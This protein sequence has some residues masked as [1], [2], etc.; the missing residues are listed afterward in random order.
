M[1]LIVRRGMGARE[2]VVV[3]I[4][5]RWLGVCARRCGSRDVSLGIHQY[6]LGDRYM[7]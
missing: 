4:C 5:K 1:W 2:V 7:A 3:G 6:L